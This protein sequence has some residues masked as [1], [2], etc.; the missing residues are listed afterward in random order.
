LAR[1]MHS[2]HERGVIHRDLTPANVLLM[3]DGTP[4][5]TDFGL[6]KIFVGERGVSSPGY[7]T[8]SGA[9]LGTPSYMPPEQAA[10]KTKETGPAGDVYALGAILYELLT[11]RPPFRAETPLETL[12]QV[13]S[14][15]PV[16]PSRL[17]PG[18]PR[19]LVT[20]CLKCLQKEPHKRYPSALALAEDLGRFLDGKSIQARRAGLPERGWRWCRRNPALASATG[21]AVAGLMAVTAISIAFAVAQFRSKAELTTAYDDL[22]EALHS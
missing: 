15:E 19:D 8:Q 20:V 16:P 9:I 11:G 4:K 1:A 12:R 10:G 3:A 17:Q 13:L 21:L 5:I 14:E 2:A 6:A 7:Q 18:L 22:Q